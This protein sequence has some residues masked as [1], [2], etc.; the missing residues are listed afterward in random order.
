MEISIKLPGLGLKLNIHFKNGMYNEFIMTC[1]EVICTSKQTT[2]IPRDQA[3]EF[4]CIQMVKCCAATGDKEADLSSYRYKI[5]LSKGT[6]REKNAA[7]VNYLV[8]QIQKK[9]LYEYLHSFWEKR[10]L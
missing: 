4:W 6:L 1:N 7:S 2:S 10:N 3:K 9:G 5:N 8:M